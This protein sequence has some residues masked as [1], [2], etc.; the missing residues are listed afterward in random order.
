MAVETIIVSRETIQTP[1]RICR[2]VAIANQKGGVGKTTTAVNLTASLAHLGHR[3]LVIDS[4][5]QGNTTS[6][7]GVDK[8]TLRGCLYNALVDG[9]DL[10][11]L[12][13]RTMIAGLD[14]VPSTMQLAGAELEIAGTDEREFR[15]Q[16]IVETMK[17]WYDYIFIDCPPSLSLLTINALTA[18]SDVVI[19][20][21]AEFYALEGLTQLNSIIERVREALNPDLHLAGAI[22]TMF[23][24]RIR[25]AV[26]VAKELETLFPA[27]VFATKVPRNVRLS[28]A[29]SFGKPVLLLD[30]RSRGA[31]AY[32]EL[33]NEFMLHVPIYVKRKSD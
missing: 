17:P 9:E 10:D 8:T 18:A 7:F 14:I 29:P 24:S 26:D 16:K 28:E 15:L 12:V 19:P 3:V 33:A 1:A 13:V 6:G 22:L 5:P 32:L 11:T 2:T 31:A 21:Q 30:P 25:L 20:V 4:D 23:D 27:H